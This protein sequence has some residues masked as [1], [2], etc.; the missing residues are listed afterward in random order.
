MS[1][2]LDT[3]TDWHL[4]DPLEGLTLGGQFRADCI[5]V[6]RASNAVDKYPN[7]TVTAGAEYRMSQINITTHKP[8]PMTTSSEAATP[9]NQPD[10]L[11][12]RPTRREMRSLE[13]AEYNSTHRFRQLGS[14]LLD[15][16]LKPVA[17]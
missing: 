4:S 15:I 14:K 8:G 11:V 3:I 12:R 2:T 13:R 7:H 10:T 16:V 17:R 5:P 1:E 9:D 6:V